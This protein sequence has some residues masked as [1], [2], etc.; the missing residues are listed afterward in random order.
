MWSGS[1]ALR[2]EGRGAV[3]DLTDRL[4]AWLSA[5]GVEEGQGTL[6]VPGSTAA[7]TSLEYEPGVV[8]DLQECLE[9]LAPAGS[10]YH[11]DRAWGDGNGYAHLRAALVGPSLAFLVRNG[12]L[13]RGTWQQVVLCDF[14]NRP[15][16]RSVEVQV[17]GRAGAP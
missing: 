16:S 8:R 15:R 5:E 2:T 12:R 11:H 1:L 17:I 7:L 3:A 9:R 10:P 6:F 14:D 13:L 4:E